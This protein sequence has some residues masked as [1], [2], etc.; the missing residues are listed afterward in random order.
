MSIFLYLSI[1]L[2]T[3]LSIFV[4]IFWYLHRN[5]YCPFIYTSRNKIIS[6][7]PLKVSINLYIYLLMFARMMMRSESSLARTAASGSRGSTTWRNTP[8]I[9]ASVSYCRS[10]LSFYSTIYLFFRLI[11]WFTYLWIENYIFIYISFH[12]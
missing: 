8:G 2:F 10:I 12:H 9:W 4:F 1:Y 6:S 11:F 3:K 7:F 5:P